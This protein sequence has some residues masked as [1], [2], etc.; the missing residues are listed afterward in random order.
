M[1]R[2]LRRAERYGGQGGK[3]SDVC[4]QRVVP[5]RGSWGASRT[6]EL[7]R[8]AGAAD[9]DVWLAAVCAGPGSGAKGV[10]RKAQRET[11]AASGQA[12]II[13]RR[14]S[15]AEPQPERNVA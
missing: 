13:Q 5:G 12:N 8:G 9:P 6:G 1:G 11:T 3:P 7:R 4:R 15:P 14:Q 2:A 10:S